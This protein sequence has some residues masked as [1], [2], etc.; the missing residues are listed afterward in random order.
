[1]ETDLSHAF[2]ERFSRFP[3]FIA[4]APG[5]VNLLGEHVDYNDGMV[6]PAAID[7]AVSLAAVPDEN[8][9]LSLHALDLDAQVTIRLDDLLEKKDV[10]GE[11]LP[12]WAC[13]PAGVA[14]ALKDAGLKVSGL[15]AIFTSDIPIGAGL[16]SSAAVEVG[17]AILWQ[18]LGGWQSDRMTLARLCQRAENDYVGVACGLMDQFASAHG[19]AKHALYFDTR[20]LEWEP[21]PLPDKTALVIADSG[22]RHSLASSGYN[23]RRATC[24]QA[25]ELLRPFKPGIKAL[26]DISPPEF[27]AFSDQ[28]PEITRRRAEHVVK[29]IARVQS[30][31]SALR[32]QDSQAFGAL[33]YACHA[34]LRDLFEVSVP[35][36]DLLVEIARE[37]PGCIGARMT[38]GGFGGCTINLVE[39]VKAPEFIRGLEQMYLEQTGRK[40]QVYLCQASDGASLLSEN[41]QGPLTAR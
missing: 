40:A 15:Q 28:L 20:S 12:E 32:R 13:Y 2:F 26:R 30:A 14:W 24:E 35:E 37:L 21:I 29:E 17:F 22:V 19:V 31:V 4:R 1:M 36:L 9:T 16:S 8:D 23:D 38:G 33:M 11:P 41:H 5:R 27:A 34:S 25:V 10:I 6:L 39:E 3:A 7:R 18:A